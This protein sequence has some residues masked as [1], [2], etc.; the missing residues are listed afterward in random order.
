MPSLAR[1][2]EEEIAAKLAPRGFVRRDLPSKSER[3]PTMEGGCHTVRTPRA[4][5]LIKPIN[6][7]TEIFLF[8]GAE[9]AK[10]KVRVDP[11][12]GVENLRMRARMEAVNEPW[13]NTHSVGHAHL[14]I[15]AGWN[16]L[17]LTDTAQVEEIARQVV[18]STVRALP[19]L[20][21]YD[22]LSKVRELFTADVNRI[23]PRPLVV[24]F[25]EEKL[26]LTLDN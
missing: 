4:A 1:Q 20:Q 22:S 14:G 24:Q 15:L 5:K 12:I 23:G 8:L 19:L 9:R 6:D 11:V 10:D 7:E 13:R 25:A 26:P 3:W 17:Y 16:L 21:Y 18:E 2:V